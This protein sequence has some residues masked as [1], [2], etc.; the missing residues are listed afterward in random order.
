MSINVLPPSSDRP[1]P[2]LQSNPYVLPPTDLS[3]HLDVRNPQ[4]ASI[5]DVGEPWAHANPNVQAS[6]SLGIAQQLRQQ[7][8][9]IE[10]T[11]GT[12]SNLVPMYSENPITSFPTLSSSYAN[13]SLTTLGVIVQNEKIKIVDGSLAPIAR[14]GQI[15]LFNGLPLHNML[16]VPRISYNLLS[17][18]KITRELNCKATFLPD[19]V[20][21]QDLSSRRM[22]VTARHNTGLYLLDDDASFSSISRTSLLSSYFSTSE[23]DLILCSNALPMFIVMVLTK[24]NS[25]LGLRLA[26]LLGILC[27]NETINAPTHL[28]GESVSEE[29]NYMVPLESTCPTV[30][31]LPDL[32][33]Y[34][35]ILPTNQDSEPIR[36]QGMT[37][38]I[39]SHSNNRMSENDRSET[40]STDS[41]TNSKVGENDRSEQLFWKIRLNVKNAFLSGDL[42]EEVYM[43]PPPGFEAQFGQEDCNSDSYVDDIVLSGD[44]QAEINQLKQRMGNE[45]EIKDLENLKYFI[46]IEVVRSKEGISVFQ[47][48]YTFHLLTETGMLGY[49]P[50]DTLIE[51]NCKL[52]NSDD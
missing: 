31:T 2:L 26:Y 24:L 8:T 37:D 12:T 42:I 4:I 39:N 34:S 35:T 6:S 3:Y 22:I 51:F 21:F 7:I 45:F 50:A 11:L 23:K 27:T 1:P 18:S 38:S 40:Y 44:D 28:H 13:A 33:P 29:S 25:L 30:V 20:S 32:S 16:H 48:K 5:F 49:R 41:H 46:G 36:D 19:S 52:E 15:S 10:A 47:R 14:K 17:I 43:S 9:A